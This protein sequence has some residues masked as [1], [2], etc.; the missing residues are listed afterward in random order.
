MSRRPSCL[1]V[2][3][4]VIGLAIGARLSPRYNVMIIDK[5]KYIANESSSRNSEVIHAGIYLLPVCS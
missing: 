3:G 5:H 1:I 4:G 2:G